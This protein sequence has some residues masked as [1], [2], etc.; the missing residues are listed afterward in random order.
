MNT[1]PYDT[2]EY[3]YQIQIAK[4]LQD[5]CFSTKNAIK[6]PERPIN[7]KNSKHRTTK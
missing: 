1:Y 4:E 5:S 2:E 6:R 7:G 3:N